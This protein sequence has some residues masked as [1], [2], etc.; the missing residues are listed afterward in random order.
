MPSKPMGQRRSIA[1]AFSTLLV[2]SF[3]F[4]YLVG[5]I[6]WFY[7]FNQ[8]VNRINESDFRFIYKVIVPTSS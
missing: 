8:N 7:Y 4:G 1:M 5:D 6:N 2:H 3:V